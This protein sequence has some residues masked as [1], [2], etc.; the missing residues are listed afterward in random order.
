MIGRKREAK[1]EDAE[2]YPFEY[3][4]GIREIKASDTI[5]HVKEKLRA[6]EYWAYVEFAWENESVKNEGTFR[7]YGKKEYGLEIVE[8]MEEPFL[9][10]VMKDNIRNFSL[11]K[12]QVIFEQVPEFT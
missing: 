5:V 4:G 8:D 9:N 6:G 12:R 7:L 3:V 10:Q 1:E 11:A 2:R